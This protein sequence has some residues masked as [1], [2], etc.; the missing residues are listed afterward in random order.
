MN[1]FPANINQLHLF[2]CLLGGSF[3][4]S[5]R[6]SFSKWTETGLCKVVFSAITCV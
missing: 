6:L 3:V 5:T 2:Y 1:A 4:I